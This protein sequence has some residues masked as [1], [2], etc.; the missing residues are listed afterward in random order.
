MTKSTIERAKKAIVLPLLLLTAA[1]ASNPDAAP[2]ERSRGM[3]ITA[4][5]GS[6]AVE[7]PGR[8][9]TCYENVRRACGDLGVDEVSMLG[10]SRVST[11]GRSGSTDD[12]F[13][14][15]DRRRR[16][17]EPISLRCKKPRNN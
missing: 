1:C 6:G 8:N 17:D 9:S 13:A 11:A 7:C 12:P 15:A 16:G 4:G 2:S 10:R 3:E 14:R 5:V